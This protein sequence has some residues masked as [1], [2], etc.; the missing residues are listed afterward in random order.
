MP[1]VCTGAGVAIWALGLDGISA[2]FMYW[3]PIL[4]GVFGEFGGIRC[5][6]FGMTA[7]VLE[8]GYFGNW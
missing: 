7:D 2:A 4:S 1:V 6:D 5:L 8:S 3:G